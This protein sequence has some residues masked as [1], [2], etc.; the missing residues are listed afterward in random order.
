MD[1][2]KFLTAEWRYLVMLNYEID[3]KVLLPFVPQGTELDQW[4]GT[5]YASM[6]GFLFLNTRI[7]GIE[8]PF[9]TNFEEVNLRFYVRR[10]D[11]GEWK[12]GVVFIK[13]IVPRFAIASMARLFYGEKY[14]AM[15]M[16]HAI[17]MRDG[18]R[19]LHVDY[20]WLFRG[21]WNHLGVSPTGSPQLVQAG[22]EEEF[23]TE[24]YWGYSSQRVGCLEYQVEH[25]R[26][27]V[28]QV[29]KS[30]FDGDAAGLYG[31]QF[32][33]SLSGAPLSAFLAEGSPVS[34]FNGTRL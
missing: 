26:W 4:N 19:D 5:T 22:S 12:R 9:H 6:V 20:G 15:P 7:K 24:H 14:A 2:N 30:W 21:C 3:P 32:V 16:R 34:V 27:Q 28:W 1:N 33:E 17:H 8:F 29:S 18:A 11:A 13:E 31:P 25:P 10:K 23:I